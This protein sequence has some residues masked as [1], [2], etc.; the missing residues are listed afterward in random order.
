MPR[1]FYFLVLAGTSFIGC[2]SYNNSSRDRYQYAAFDTSSAFGQAMQIFSTRCITCHSYFGTYT[3][4]ALWKSSGFVT[5]G[6]LTASKVYYRLNGAGLGIA[7]EDMPQGGVLSSNDL[8]TIRN[9]ILNMA[10]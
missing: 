1:I 7:A 9:W 8:Q 2:Q 4:E 10:P 6:S 3:T 5:A